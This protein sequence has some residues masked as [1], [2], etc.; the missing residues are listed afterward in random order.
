MFSLEV[1]CQNMLTLIQPIFFVLKMF[2][3]YVCCIY[4][5]VHLRLD[6]IMA[7]NTLNPDQGAVGAEQSVNVQ[8]CSLDERLR[9][10]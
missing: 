10:N 1:S 5:Q 9:I 4:I 3:F 8:Q 2:A 6:F 7:A